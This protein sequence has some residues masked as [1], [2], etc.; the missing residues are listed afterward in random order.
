MLDVQVGTELV[1]LVL[2]RLSTLAQAE[3]AIGKLFSI[4]REN[5]A[6]ADRAGT[7]QVSQE[8][9]SIRRSLYLE[10]ADENPTRRA[11]YGHKQ[12]AA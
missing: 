2:A 9:P 5:R 8:A 1:E 10:N 12:I 3:E 7:F 6:N 11:V 4:V